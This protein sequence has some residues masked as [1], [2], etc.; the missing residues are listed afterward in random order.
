MN[1]IYMIY[2]LYM[3]ILRCD[4]C[5]YY[6]VAQ[7]QLYRLK[8]L[9]FLHRYESFIVLLG[10]GLPVHRP[11]SVA[12]CTAKNDGSSLMIVAYSLS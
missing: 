12:S 3:D 5:L 4:D 7:S 1:I 6:K 10:L 2:I 11:I 8:S 9:C